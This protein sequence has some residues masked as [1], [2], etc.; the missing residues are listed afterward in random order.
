MSEE[1]TVKFGR[2]TMAGQIIAPGGSWV[3]AER[4]GVRTTSFITLNDDEARSL[5]DQMNESFATNQP[6]GQHE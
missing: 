5:R 2:L 3:I 1:R 4:H 6:E